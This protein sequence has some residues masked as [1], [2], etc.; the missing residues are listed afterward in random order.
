MSRGADV[1]ATDGD[2]KTAW[3]VR[4]GEPN[5]KLFENDA[6]VLVSVLVDEHGHEVD[7]RDDFGWTPLHVAVYESNP[8]AA[9]GLPR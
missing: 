3:Q 1:H 9:T 2:G 6:A 7:A 4:W 5:R 8:E